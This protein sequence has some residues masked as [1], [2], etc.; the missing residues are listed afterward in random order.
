MAYRIKHATRGRE[1]GSAWNA[2]RANERGEQFEPN[3]DPHYVEE[4]GGEQVVRFRLRTFFSSST[5]I[6][7]RRQHQLRAIRLRK[8]RLIGHRAR[9]YLG[10]E[11]I[12]CDS[13]F[14]LL[15]GIS[16]NS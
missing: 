2:Y 15:G 13:D 8:T 3:R 11:M 9:G 5:A 4:V 14:R 10:Y 16:G 12:W 7:I 6:S 1:L